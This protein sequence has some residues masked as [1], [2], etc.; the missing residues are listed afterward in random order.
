[1]SQDNKVIFTELPGEVK[2]LQA[3]GSDDTLAC[4]AIVNSKFDAVTYP[5]N[6]HYKL[7]NEM[8]ES[9]H[10]G[11]LDHNFITMKIDCT[12]ASAR[13]ILRASNMNFNELS[14]RYLEATPKFY[15]PGSFAVDVKRK[16]LANEPLAL[17]EQEDTLAT[18]VYVE[19]VR[20]SYDCYLKLRDIGVRKEQARFV[21]PLS[22]YTSFWMS[23]RL[24]DWYHFL[25]LR[26]DAHTQMETKFIA[27]KMFEL[28]RDKY[29]ATTANWERTAKGPLPSGC[30]QTP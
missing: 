2:L 3:T 26:L 22:F 27:Q 9:G 29:P 17:S 1:M 12:I 30:I 10:W 15:L 6:R 28:I 8:V 7:V 25:N 21:L 14:L 20:N 24:S 11:C 18:E 5:E 16:E 4:A 13:Q 23:G 19:S